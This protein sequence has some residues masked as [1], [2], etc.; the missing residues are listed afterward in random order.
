MAIDSKTR[1]KAYMDGYD[2]SRA[3]AS[4]NSNPYK[5]GVPK[6][7]WEEGWAVAKGYLAART[8]AQVTDYP[9]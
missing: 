2:A 7:L 9:F 3:G 6:A 5:D 4:L 8:Y 1:L